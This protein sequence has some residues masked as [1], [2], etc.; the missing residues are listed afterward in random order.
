MAQT[1]SSPD[2]DLSA[3]PPSVA[4]ATHA[5]EPSDPTSPVG[6]AELSLASAPIDPATVGE[7]ASDSV[8]IPPPPAPP[9]ASVPPPAQ[10]SGSVPPPA[11]DDSVASFAATVSSLI[12]QAGRVAGVEAYVASI[13]SEPADEL[14]IHFPVRM[15]DG[16]VRLFKGYRVQH[17]NALGPFKG[18]VRFHESVTLDGCRAIA[19]MAT[20][21]C[22]LLRLPFGGG[23][24]GIKF[25]P[26]GVSAAE[27]QRI[28]RRFF[29]S[30]GTNAGP[31]SDVAH[32]DL[33]TNSQIMAWALDTYA[34]TVGTMLAEG[35]RAV[36]TGKP[37]A[38]GGL[39]GR[40]RAAGQGVVHVIR[41]WASDRNFELAGA[42]L[43][44]LGFGT[45]GANT[46]MLLAKLGVSTVA[47]A[48]QTGYL[49]NEEGINAHKLHE[50]VQRTGGIAGYPGARRVRHDEFYSLRTDIFLPAALPQQVGLGE[51]DLL[52]ARLV[53]EGAQGPL[54]P[55]AENAL[56]ARGIDILPDLLV[57]GANAA[58]SYYEWAQNKRSETWAP[59]VVEH[60]LETLMRQAYRE[61]TQ[62]ARTRNLSLRLAAY[63]VAIGRLQAVYRERDLFPLVGRFPTARAPL[64]PPLAAA[65]GSTG[66]PRRESDSMRAAGPRPARTQHRSRRREPK[67]VR[68]DQHRWAARKRRSLSTR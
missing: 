33:G 18:G 15:D 37:V 40:E 52:E 53:V 12:E 64:G 24:G 35:S 26:R 59:G 47:V 30:F 23:A 43:K 8:S 36:V 14:I 5:L 62:L 55:D 20:F 31:E 7:G 68:A 44:A 67:P 65:R 19:S 49:I 17:S 60:K 61:V 2:A 22:A 41:Q 3:T 10:P 9:S 1:P 46:A 58:L 25:D 11:T 16:T 63:V 39:E 29:F 48:D 57:N 56:I 13:L 45:T 4:E 28:S 38:S 50:H 66:E 6:P 54:T 21:Q 32:P 51:A 27:L 34:S 42:T